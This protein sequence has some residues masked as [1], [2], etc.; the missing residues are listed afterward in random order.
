ML[1]PYAKGRADAD[2]GRA[3]E[4]VKIKSAFMGERTSRIHTRGYGWGREDWST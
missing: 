2:V 4:G 1:S 3:G